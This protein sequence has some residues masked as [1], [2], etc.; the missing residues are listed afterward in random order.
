MGTAIVETPNIQ[1]VDRTKST[2]FRGVLVRDLLDRF[3]ADPQAGEITFVCIDGFR[4]TVR[5][6]DARK[7]RMLLAIEADGRPIERTS[8]GP[9]YLIHPFSEAPELA[10]VYPDRFWAFYVT[11][12]VVGTEDVRVR[13]GDRTFDRAALENLPPVRWETP[14]GWKVDWPADAVHLRGVRLVDALDVAGV[15][16]PPKGRVV[17][18]GK[19]PVHDDPE[20]PIAIAVADLDACRPVLALRWGND[21]KPIPAK[22]GGPVALAITPCGPTYG[23]RPWVTFVESIQV[24]P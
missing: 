13:I 17:I 11:H 8:G 10:D 6:A 7:Y 19:A 15:E 1:I 20:R 9:I 12:V 24:M 4:A 23:E 2:K 22:L 16:L 14:V 18:R 3:D 21:E 5:L